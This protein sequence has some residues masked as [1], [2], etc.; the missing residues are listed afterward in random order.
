MKIIKKNPEYTEFTEYTEINFKY[1][2]TLCF[3]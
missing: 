3:L 2:V 1:F